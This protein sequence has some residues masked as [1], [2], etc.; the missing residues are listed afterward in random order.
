MHCNTQHMKI[1][2]DIVLIL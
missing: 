1:T 2:L